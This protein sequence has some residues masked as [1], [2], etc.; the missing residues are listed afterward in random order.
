MGE[1]EAETELILKELHRD[2]R[3]EE[4]E[5]EGR[6]QGVLGNSAGFGVRSGFKSLYSICL[7]LYYFF[8]TVF[9]LVKII[10]VI[11]IS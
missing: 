7:N 9:F 5:K 8:L 1:Q 10:T 3:G 6:Y 4:K 11:S 2:V